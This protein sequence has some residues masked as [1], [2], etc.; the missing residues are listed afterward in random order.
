MSRTARI[1]FGKGIV[2]HVTAGGTVML[3]TNPDFVAF[4]TIQ[5]DIS[6]AQA[7]VTDLENQLK[8]ARLTV[9]NLTDDWLP[10]VEQLS[11]TGDSLAKGDAAEIVK[12]GFTPTSSAPPATPQLSA[13]VE[14]LV[15]TAGDNDG[16]LDYTHEREEHATG[17]ERQ[18]TLTPNDAA[19]WVPRESTTRSSG[20]VGGLPCGSR[21]WVRVRAIG[22]MGAG[23][24]S[25]PATKIVP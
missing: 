9:T 19:S 12:L 18:T 13:Q 22:A 7:V 15:V 1:T 3:V 8:A 11:K 24:W 20:T 25:D 5:T 23:P 6:D 4:S 16:E 14:G 21:Q 17:Y 10:A 2:D